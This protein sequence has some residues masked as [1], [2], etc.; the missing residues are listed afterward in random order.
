M[1][2]RF[3]VFLYN[4]LRS[5]KGSFY[6]IKFRMLGANI[7][8]GVIF[9]G[10]PNFIGDLRN[11]SIGKNSTINQGVFFNCADKII[12]GENCRLSSFSQFHTGALT[13]TC[14]NDRI[15]YSKPIELGDNVWISSGV[16]VNP[17]IIISSGAVIAPGSVVTKAIP[18][19]EFHGGVPTRFIKKID[20]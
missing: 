17:G 8:S 18:S 7:S 11:L 10:E 3:F 1:C 20:I 9:Y 15:H 14:K 19:N 16:I 6:K 5:L 12:I 4:R 2:N 13:M